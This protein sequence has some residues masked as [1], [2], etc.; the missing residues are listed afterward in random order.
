MVDILKQFHS[1]L[2]QTGDQD[3]DGQQFSDDQFTIERAVNAIASVANG[4]TPEDRLEGINMRL[5]DWHAAMKLLTVSEILLT[6]SCDKRISRVIII[7]P[8]FQFC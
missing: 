8:L 5:G 3:V 6:C 2:P 1:Y 4:L 7:F